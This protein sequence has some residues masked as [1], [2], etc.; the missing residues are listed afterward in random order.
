MCLG[1]KKKSVCVC[2]SLHTCVL[3]F[4]VL[5]SLKGL[6]ADAAGKEPL[7]ESHASK[8]EKPAKNSISTSFEARG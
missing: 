8:R 5:E 4:A 1:A 3:A 7:L 6:P 2:V